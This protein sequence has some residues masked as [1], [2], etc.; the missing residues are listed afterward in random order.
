LFLA[1]FKY[2][3]K[4]KKDYENL[5]WKIAIKQKKKKK[6]PQF[7]NWGAFFLFTLYP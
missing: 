1:T 3:L 7:L 4:N 2:L 6:R 5:R